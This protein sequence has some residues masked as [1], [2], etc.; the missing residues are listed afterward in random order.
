MK[1]THARTADDVLGAL[2]DYRDELHKARLWEPHWPLLDR[3]ITREVEMRLVW[4]EIARY[5]LTAEQCRTLLEQLFFAGACGT[6]DEQKRLKEDY[7]NLIRLNAVIAARAAELA[8]MLNERD[9]ILNRNT[10]ESNYMTEIVSLIDSSSVRNGYYCTHLREPLEALRTRYDGK[11]WPSLQQLLEVVARENP[12]TAFTD[13]SDDAIIRAR[14]GG[15]SVFLRALF[16]RIHD[17][18]LKETEW[19]YRN[20]YLPANVRMTDGS[21]ATLASVSL[22]L[23]EPATVESVKMQRHRLHKA[24]YPGAWATPGVTINDN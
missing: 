11:Y 21:L 1:N 24:G 23:D 3:L 19:Q 20:I 2:K 8:S 6:A 14:G 10:F 17:I 16:H 5:V 4:E 13:R 9:A 12:A 18:R 7:E 22:D 15:L